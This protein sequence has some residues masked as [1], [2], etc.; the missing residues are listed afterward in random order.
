MWDTKNGFILPIQGLPIHGGHQESVHFANPGVVNACGH[1][2][3]VPFANPGVANAFGTPRMGPL[4]QSRGC[5]GASWPLLPA[6]QSQTQ[7]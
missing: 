2:Q 6:G 7:K 5:K 4:C 1:R 3:C